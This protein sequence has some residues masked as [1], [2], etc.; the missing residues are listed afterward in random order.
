MA[1]K[2]NVNTI[3]TQSGTV[4]TIPTGKSLAI[5]DAGAFTIGGAPLSV[6]SNTV[7]Y[8]AADYTIL[9]TDVLGKTECVVGAHAG[10]GNR[11]ITLPLVTEPGMDTCMITCV[12]TQDSGTYSYMKVG[13][14]NGAELW[15]GV[16]K[17][18]YVT[19]YS[20]SV[21]KDI[22]MGQDVF[23]VIHDKTKDVLYVTIED[24]EE[25]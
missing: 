11:T 12:C 22:V 13:A 18:D 10:G 17:G 15:R 3:D 25:V 4:V 8:E 2:I 16:Q 23:E 6:G 1:S 19:V 5:T 14:A 21:A 20:D 24:I 7:R 9:G